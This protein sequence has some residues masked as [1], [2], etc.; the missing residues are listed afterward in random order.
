MS[1][2]LLELIKMKDEYLKSE[3][4]RLE[5]VR[6]SRIG[7]CRGLQNLH[8]AIMLNVKADPSCLEYCDDL[9]NLM[10]DMQAD[11]DDVELKQNEIKAILE[12]KKFQ[13]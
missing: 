2:D 10:R 12:V 8:D 4:E 6:M 3:Y 13:R 9:T 5:S 11:I 1:K 7:Y